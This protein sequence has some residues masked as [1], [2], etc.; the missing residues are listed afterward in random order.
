MIGLIVGFLR[1]LL[2]YILVIF[3]SLFIEKINKNNHKN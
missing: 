1:L 2:K 3:P